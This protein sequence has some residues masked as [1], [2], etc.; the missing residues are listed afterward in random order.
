MRDYCLGLFMPIEAKSVAL[1]GGSDSTGAG[2]RAG[3]NICSILWG[4]HRGRTLR[5]WP[6]WASL[7]SPVI[8]RG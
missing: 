2:R 1:D 3:I 6:G 4:T 8:E 5:C 7:C